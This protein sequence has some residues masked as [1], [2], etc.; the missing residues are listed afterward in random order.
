[1]PVID[2]RSNDLFWGNK[3]RKNDIII[4]ADQFDVVVR[5][6]RPVAVVVMDRHLKDFRAL[7]FIGRFTAEKH[8]GETTVFTN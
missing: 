7:G 1:V 4:S 8:I 3:L 2:A 5:Q 6:P